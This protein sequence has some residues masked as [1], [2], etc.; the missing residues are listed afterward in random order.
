MIKVGSW[1]EAQSL[2]LEVERRLNVSCK[3]V[4]RGFEA[5]YVEPIHLHPKVLAAMKYILADLRHP[6]L[7]EVEHNKLM[8][9]RLRPTRS[10]SV[11][12]RPLWKDDEGNWWE[13]SPD[14]GFTA[15]EW[16]NKL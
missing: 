5:Y 1:E 11:N 13:E 16:E 6:S 12:R 3:P 10:Q 7:F 14:G 15:Y 4:V 2:A 9:R 8:P